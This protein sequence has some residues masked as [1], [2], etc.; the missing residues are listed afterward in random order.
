MLRSENYSMINYDNKSFRP[1]RSSENSE[2]SNET[3]FLYRQVGTILTAE[4]ADGK[5]RKGQL[6][7]IVDQQGVI[8]MRYQQVNDVGQLMTGICKSTPEVLP[9][10]KIR[11]HEA[12]EWT[13]GDRSTGHSIVDEE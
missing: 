2:T 7:G 6:I 13:S 1:V 4:Y 3:V 11:L 5:I 12:W 9:S 8:D 10:G